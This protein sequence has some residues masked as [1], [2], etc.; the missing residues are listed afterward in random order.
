MPVAL[1][2]QNCI[3]R[4]VHEVKW[5]MTQFCI[6]QCFVMLVVVHIVSD[7]KKLIM[8]KKNTTYT[9]QRQM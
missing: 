8:V 6:W 5:P 7:T 1:F 4:F 2:L 9:K 3:R